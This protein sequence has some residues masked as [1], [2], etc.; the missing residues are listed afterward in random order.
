LNVVAVLVV[1]MEVFVLL[2]SWNVSRRGCGMRRLMSQMWLF[3]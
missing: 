3:L 1:M 2:V